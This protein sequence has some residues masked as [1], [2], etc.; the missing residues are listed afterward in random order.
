M[1][2]VFSDYDSDIPTLHENTEEL[3]PGSTLTVI[4]A[5][6]IL[7]SWFAAFPGISKEALGRLLYI[8]HT[9]LLPP[10]N[11]LPSS[12]AAAHAIVKHHLVQPIEYHCCINDC[13]LFRDEYEQLVQCPKC[14]EDRYY[15][16]T[17]QPRKRFKYLPVLPRIKRMYSIPSLAKLMQEH[18]TVSSDSEHSTVV[19]DIHQSVTWKNLYSADG[20]YKG[21]VSAVSFSLC[22]DGMNP[23]SKEKVAYS[24]WPIT[25]SILNLP[26]HIRTKFGSLLLVGIIPGSKEPRN[27][28]PYLQ[29]V[30]EDVRSFSSYEI[31][32]SYRNI[33]I[34]LQA[35]IVLNILDYPGHNKVFKCTGKP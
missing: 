28:D 26:S 14:G 6:A 32:D 30:I 24:M 10:E 20:A 16:S 8:L 23:F 11:K 21:D 13:I 22:T 17:V 7:Y 33:P 18:I 5:L 27:M 29:L 4:S 9:Y 15:S 34:R 1:P 31:I 3:F 25:L 2:E 19:N 35:S 12:Y